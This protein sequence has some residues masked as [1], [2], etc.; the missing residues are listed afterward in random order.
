MD[1]SIVIPAYNE[2][3]RLPQTLQKVTAHLKKKGLSFEVIVVDD[4]SRDSTAKWVREAGGVCP[5]IKLF[6][7][8]QNR[9]KG[10]SVRRGVLAAAGEYILYTDSDLS[11]PIEELDNLL[12]EMAGEEADIVIGS[13]GLPESRIVIKQPWYRRLPGKL[14]PLLVKILVTGRY[15]DTQCGFKLLRRDVAQRLFSRM[16][17]NGFSFDVELLYRA[18]KER[19]RV[20]EAPVT[21]RNSKESKVVLWRDPPLMVK[22]LFRIRFQR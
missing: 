15:R 6:S 7:N 4:G 5:E 17:S 8:R 20:K 21:W 12:A 9:G 18:Q 1:I 19:C 11:T 2:A 22:D 16:K 14:Y 3:K 13:R 10:F